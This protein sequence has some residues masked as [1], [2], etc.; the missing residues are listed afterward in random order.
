MRAATETLH[1]NQRTVKYVTLPFEHTAATQDLSVRSSKASRSGR[2][3]QCTGVAT[4]KSH[5]RRA[6]QQ[7]SMRKIKRCPMW[8]S[9][10][11]LAPR[12]FASTMRTNDVHSANCHKSARNI[13]S[14]ALVRPLPTARKIDTQVVPPGQHPHIARRPLTR[15]SGRPTKGLGKQ[16]VCCT[17]MHRWHDK[18]LSVKLLVPQTSH[19]G[20]WIEVAT[21]RAERALIASI[22]QGFVNR[23]DPS[24][25]VVGTGGDDA[26]VPVSA[27]SSS[28]ISKGLVQSRI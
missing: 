20:C 14:C 23:K 11:R 9:L 10:S 1:N 28:A 21:A 13:G 19:L 2:V 25:V 24:V 7:P 6:Q 4:G 22:G 16:K 3:Q 15:R 26:M 17:V 5:N 18:M 27:L 12:W 8:S